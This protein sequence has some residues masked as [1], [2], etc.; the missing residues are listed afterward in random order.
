MLVA[1]EGDEDVSFFSAFRDYVGLKD[2]QV[3]QYG[4]KGNF[5]SWIS[6]LTKVD[7]FHAVQSL[8]LVRDANQ[9]ASSAFQ[10]VCDALTAAG[11]TAP[12][13][14]LQV[15]G[16][17]PQIVVLIVPHG[18]SSGML[19]DL[20][21]ESVTSDPAMECVD[22]FLSCVHTKIGSLPHN[23]A[24]AKIHAFL[25]TRPEPDKRLGEAA[26]ARYW[27]WTSQAFD[28]VRQFFTLL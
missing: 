5:R 15:A 16:S 11:L 27:P 20:C 25:A 24:K 3:M 28:S 12:V 19:E 18:S 23:P 10:S 14:P 21:L 17:N 8:G 26:K 6:T 1:V 13:N 9:N 4:G 22:Q 7:G 2:V